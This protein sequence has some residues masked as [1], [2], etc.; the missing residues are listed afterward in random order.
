MK[1]ASAKT[2]Y[3]RSGLWPD[4][5]SSQ[6]AKLTAADGVPHD[7]FGGSVALSGDTVL[8]GAYFKADMAVTGHTGRHAPHAMHSFGSI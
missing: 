2:G 5:T 1:I 7:S 3:Q 6:Q 4:V 8:V